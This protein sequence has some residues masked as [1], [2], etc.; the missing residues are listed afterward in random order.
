MLTTL[1]TFSLSTEN[2]NSL[3]DILDTF[4]I[5]KKPSK[6]EKISYYNVASAFDIEVSSFDED[7]EKRACMYIWVFGI[8]G[9]AILGRTWQE[10]L[11]VCKRLVEYYDLSLNQR[12]IIWVHNLSYEFQFIRKMFKWHQVFA[13]EN[14][15]VVYAVTEDGIE[16]RC[17]YKL[18]NLSL[19]EVGKNL[20]K[21]PVEKLVGDLDY[22]LVRS[23]KTP[24]TQKEKQYVINDALVVMSLI[25]EKLET[26]GNITSLPLTNTGYVRKHCRKIL[27]KDYFGPYS[28][29]IK[30][31]TL[32]EDEY[33]Q[34]KR[35]FMG[36]FTHANAYRVG[37]TYKNVA[38][39]D[40]T[41][42]YPTVMLSE[43]F[44]MSKGKYIAIKSNEQ[45][46]YMLKHYCCLFD[47]VFT[48]LCSTTEQ[49]HYISSSKAFIKEGVL[50]DNGR[51]I[52]ADKLGLSITEQDFFIIT[53]TY[54]W[55]KL[56]IANFRY[57]QKG[58]LPK[59]F[60]EI[61][62]ELYKDK[63][64]LKGIKGE[65][66]RYQ[67]AKG[68]LNSMY[69]MCV[70]DPCRA[71]IDYEDDIWS[72]EEVN[73]KE[74]ITKY[75]ESKNRFL[76][77]AWG[78]WI[79]AYARRNLW[80]AILALGQDYIYADTDSVKVLNIEKHQDYFDKYNDKIV[81]KISRVLNFYK[82]DLD[83]QRPKNIKGETKQIGIWDY[84]GTYDLFK[85]LGAKRYLTYKNGDLQITVS[86]IAK[87]NGVNYLLSTYKT[88]KAIFDA[89]E[90]GILF[91]GKYKDDAGNIQSATGKNT[92]SY[93]D[94]ETQGTFVDYLGEEFNYHEM[95]SI[96]MSACDYSLS[97]A[98]D[99][100]NYLNAILL[101]LPI[102]L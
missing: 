35:A 37:K 96:N 4:K 12:F 59:D 23:S 71:D 62:L 34:L 52:M 93:I 74:A 67:R 15:E 50:K 10:F 21:Y 28:K 89:F 14:R 41:S 61:V 78:V 63:T 88:P 99:F 44:P 49:D 68:M 19:K 95:S 53:K 32:E 26:E 101:G 40:F 54:T 90:E 64:E 18:T 92:L 31:M 17:S 79:T 36:G 1:K 84:E 73:E 82:L 29:M 76:F 7:G 3:E 72:T 87:Q 46:I 65:E 42:S 66:A 24:L 9:K 30:K 8:N 86:G 57:Y 77:Y 2:Y 11:D 58:F 55:E 60:I 22:N 70:T 43:V 75:N 100:L 20:I 39:F 45:F 97:I 25:Q 94:F 69:G 98:Q 51:V 85:T 81:N 91:P 80:S 83:L 102:H 16:F 38:S 13:L 27:L 47:V 48:N 56:E 33:K 5:V 6:R